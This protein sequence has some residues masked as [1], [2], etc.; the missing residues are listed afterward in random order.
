MSDANNSSHSEQENN[1]SSEKT[2]NTK[3]TVTSV[4]IAMEPLTLPLTHAKCVKLRN[5]YN[6]LEANSQSIERNKLI[7]DAK[8]SI[9]VEFRTKGIWNPN[10]DTHWH[11][12]DDEK[13]F[14]KLLLCFPADNQATTDD[15]VDRMLELLRKHSITNLADLP[16]GAS[17]F[18]QQDPRAYH[19]CVRWRR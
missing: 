17:N 4:D 3:V 18:Q 6:R 13:F 8:A 14:Q 19:L 1:N 10:E 9:G 2:T 15:P 11:D 16:G 7:N 5:Q 12:W